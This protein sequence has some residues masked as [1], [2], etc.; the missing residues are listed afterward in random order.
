MDRRPIRRA[1]HGIDSNKVRRSLGRLG[2]QPPLCGE[3]KVARQR[4]LRGLPGE[5]DHGVDGG[6]NEGG[7]AVI[8]PIPGPGTHPHD[9]M[10]DYIPAPRREYAP[11]KPA[12]EYR[13]TG[14]TTTGRPIGGK[15]P[16]AAYWREIKRR[17]ARAAADAP[18]SCCRVFHTPAARDG[19]RHVS[20]ELTRKKAPR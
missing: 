1:H 4:A 3:W 16:R 17:K 19:A 11:R 12:Y 18:P 2:S 5:A 8:L 10:P 15:H 20:S 13:S 9:W 6:E 7:E 14:R